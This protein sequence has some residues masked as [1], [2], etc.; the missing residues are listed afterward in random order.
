MSD[1]KTALAQIVAIARRNELSIGDISNAL[2]QQTSEEGEQD[3]G[4]VRRLLAYIGGILVFA[5]VLVYIQMFWADM[6]SAARIIVTLG[7]GMAALIIAIIFHDHDRFSQAA[8]PLLL[9]AAC[10][11]PWGI[12]VA[13]NELGTGGDPQL[14]A[15]LATGTMLLQQLLIMG[16]LQRT[17]VLFNALLFGALTVSNALDLIGVSEEVNLVIIG[18]S[19]LLL[20]YGIDQTKHRG[21]IP[22]WYLA[23]SAALFWGAFE[24]LRQTPAHFAYL[25]LTAFMIYLSTAARSQTLLFSST[26]AMIGYL[27][28]FTAQYFVDSI[29]WPVSL[30]FMGLLLL[31]ISNMALRI[32]RK[33][34]A[35]AW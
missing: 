28:Y 30:I 16:R 5:G 10:L 25:G 14:A 27:T 2:S 32:N 13:F 4:I 21:I 26:V 12:M 34:I 3:G 29:G 31:G 23:G 24:L 8:T 18:L 11:Q 17:V 6:N 9:I 7:T 22:F 1:K 33:Y 20:S 19:L 15:L 35:G